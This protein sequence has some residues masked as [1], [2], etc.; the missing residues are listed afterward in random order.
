MLV[1]CN[2]ICPSIRYKR[3]WLA[4][5]DNVPPNCPYGPWQAQYLR[6]EKR[7]IALNDQ[8]RS[9]IVCELTADPKC[10]LKP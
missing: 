2:T 1:D 10:D 9:H 7:C 3:T 6:L 5:L 4:G 8:E